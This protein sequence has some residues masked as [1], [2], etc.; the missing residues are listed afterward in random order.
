MVRLVRITRTTYNADNF[1][2]ITYFSNFIST[3]MLKPRGAPFI[4]A[5]ESGRVPR[6]LLLI[7]QRNAAV[8]FVLVDA[9]R[10]ALFTPVDCLRV[11]SG[12][13][14]R[15]CVV[16]RASIVARHWEQRERPH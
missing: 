3:S 16:E 4:T 15:F 13:S 5:A 7:H 9:A 6:G 14:R 8:F 2:A 11:H 10:G 12:L 1:A